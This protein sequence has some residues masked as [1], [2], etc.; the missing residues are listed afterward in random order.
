MGIYTNIQVKSFGFEG[1]AIVP[2]VSEHGAILLPQNEKT[3]EQYT[4]KN[5]KIMG[6]DKS[7]GKW[8]CDFGMEP[9]PTNDS[10]TV[11]ITDKRI[12]CITSYVPSFFGG[13]PVQKNGKVSVGQVLLNDVGSAEFYSSNGQNILS[14]YYRRSD[15][16]G[17]NFC[18]EA[19]KTVLEAIVNT[20]K[21]AKSKQQ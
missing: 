12:T 21:S 1:D 9:F 5:V 2:P 19:D 20:I 6:K 8:I 16:A 10:W 14:L 4:V 15:G 18:I 3:I 7:S 13:K 11:T 17:L